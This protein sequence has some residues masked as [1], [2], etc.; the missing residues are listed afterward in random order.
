M[1]VAQDSKTLSLCTVYLDSR[2]LVRR[3]L[4]DFSATLSA[5]G[6]RWHALDFLAIKSSFNQTAVDLRA[7]NQYM[8]KR[9][10]RVLITIV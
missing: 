3:K 5:E 8:N 10:Y 1:R 7:S 4:Y 6:V 2:I 9:K